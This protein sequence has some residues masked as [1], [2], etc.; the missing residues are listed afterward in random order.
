[1]F[2]AVPRVPHLR[3]QLGVLARR[4]LRAVPQL[5]DARQRRAYQQDVHGALGEAVRC[6]HLHPVRVYRRPAGR[7]VANTAAAAVAFPK[8]S[9]GAGASAGAVAVPRVGVD[10]RRGGGRGA[11]V[12][13]AALEL[14]ESRGGGEG[15]STITLKR[16]R[17]LAR[18]SPRPPW[19]HARRGAKTPPWSC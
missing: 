9:A 14:Q 2:Q 19:A 8:A 17:C 6:V 5:V 1:M 12:L 13:F 15:S 10:G 7:P 3:D 4:D 16:M 18:R 11:D